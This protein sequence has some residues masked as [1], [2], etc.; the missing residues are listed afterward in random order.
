[1]SNDANLRQDYPIPENE[2]ERLL[3]VLAYDYADGGPQE[4]LHQICYLAQSLFDVPIAL[5]S[6]VGRN[7]QTFLAKSGIDA[8]STPRKDAFCAH[9]ILQDEVLVVTDP[10]HDPR[11]AANPFVTGAAHI[12]FYAGAP[13]IL[14][15]EIRIGALCLLDTKLRSF[16]EAD[17]SR[18]KILA[19]MVIGE[20]HRR[21]TLIDLKRQ[22]DMKARAA[23]MTKVGSWVMDPKTRAVVWSPQTY[24]IFELDHDVVPTLAI[25]RSFPCSDWILEMDKAILALIEDGTPLDREYQIVTARGR[26]RWIHCIA[27]A[28]TVNGVVTH[29]AGSIQDISQQH[30][31]AAEIER[32]AFRDSLTGLPNRA[33]FQ[34]RF[35]TAVKEAERRGSKVGL[36]LLDLDHF[37]DVNDTLGHDAGDALLR[38]VSERLLSVYRKTDTVARVGGD[39][40]AVILPDIRNIEDLTRPTEQLM[41]LLRHPLEHQGKSLSISASIGGAVYPQDEQSPEQLM[42]NADIALYRAKE[43]GRNRL[44]AFEPRMRQAVEQRMSLLRE[45][46]GGIRD[47]QFDLYYQPLVNIAS[48]QVTGFEALMRWCHPSRGLLTPEN[49]LIGFEDQE[50]SL[51]L[52]EFA[53]DTAMAQMR[54]W[55]DQKLEFGRVAVNLSASQFRTGNLVETVV[56][57]LRDWR[58]PP[59]RLTLEVTENVYMG[60][61]SDIVG[62]T[63]RTLHASGIL[64]ALDDFGTGYASL[65]NLK[66]FPIDRLKIDKSFV[67]S[68]HDAAIV[69]AVLTMGASMGMKVVAEGVETAQ[70]LKALSDMGCDQAQGYLFAKPMP[71]KEVSAFLRSFI[72]D[73]TG[74]HRAV[75]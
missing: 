69:Q 56:N 44:V 35:A 62:D 65:T 3:E 26:R 41:Q 67:Q 55:L 2:G 22:R 54:T 75:A 1:M 37:K 19:N 36:L 6:L 18:L 9:A 10:A 33:L 43:G 38:S 25:L 53:L 15:P 64:I 17:A 31:H 40:F 60:W 74:T 34:D 59:E 45:I 58:V 66:Q 24:E 49:F 48:R 28:E 16:S 13:L 11:F 7:E 61:G 42:K 8:K 71:G 27:E 14:S 23:R 21:R 32:L 47:R 63:I 12:R 29:V 46:R 72:N 39:E 52:G 5:V 73:K 20:L 51:L 4:S 70:Q 50:L 30:E 57:K 68:G